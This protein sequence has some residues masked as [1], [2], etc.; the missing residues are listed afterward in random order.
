MNLRATNKKEM[1]NII[2]IV[3]SLLLIALGFYHLH[4]Q[5]RYIK[6]GVQIIA[7][8][9]NVLVHPTQQEGQTIEEYKKELE[10]YNFLLEDYKRQGIIK[11]SSAIAI[12][13]A[14][15]Y[16]NKE[17]VT[18]LGYFS[19]ELRIASTVTIYANKD[20]PLDFIYDGAN[21]FGL[22]FC[23]VVGSVMHIFSLAFFFVLKHNKKCNINLKEKGKLIQAEIIFADEEENKSSFDKHP[24]V[25]TCLFKDEEKNEQ[26]YFTSESIYCKN[27]G[28]N[29]IGKKVDIYVDPNDYKNYYID[30]QLFEK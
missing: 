27:N 28:A 22:Y 18:E 2:L 10:H 7:V 15:E 21:K 9:E 26:I 5:N 1:I 23:M 11:E 12:I 14:Y 4:E 24:F 20:N 17:Y 16:N 6:E 29:Y 8:V 25:F 13:I 19:N 30:T 3:I